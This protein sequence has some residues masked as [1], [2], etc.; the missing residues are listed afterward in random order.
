MKNFILFVLLC[1]YTIT[2]LG[3][4]SLQYSLK[5]GDVFEIKQHANQI[6][7]QELDGAS[8]EIT[9]VIQGVLSFTVTGVEKNQYKISL[10]FKDLN[11]KMDS[12]IQGTIMDVK[13]LEIEEGD[14]Q[15]KIFNSLLNSPVEMTLAKNGDILNVIGGDSLVSKMTAAS[16][17]AD[18]FS[19]NLMRKSLEKEFGSKALSDSYKQMTFIY[20][21]KAIKK[22]DSWKNQYTGKLTAENTWVLEDYSKENALIN[23]TSAVSMNLVEPGTTMTLT[24]TQQTKITTNIISG[25]IETMIVTS[26]TK[27][28][29]TV[30]QMNNQEIPT[31]IESTTTYELIK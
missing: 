13:A 27:G 2:S 20:P 30:A 19:I 4:V 12:S 3:Q 21:D 1:S 17:L 25:F 29:S 28:T 23:G 31:T 22:G 6:I 16:G 24:G 8:H 14:M 26:I 18:E 15:S 7:T 10:S 9:N 11:L 5:K